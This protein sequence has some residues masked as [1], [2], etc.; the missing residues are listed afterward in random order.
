M[1]P[2]IF[3]CAGPSLSDAERSFFEEEQPAG[4]IL[5]ARNIVSPQQL[6]TLTTD[7]RLSVGRADVPILIDQ[8]GGRVQRMGPPHWQKYPA[9]GWYAAK[10]EAQPLLSRRALVLGCK[11]IADDLLRVGINV[12]CLPLLDVPVDGA[13]NI[14]G[15]RSFGFDHQTVA[16]LGQLVVTTLKNAGVHPVIKHIPGHGRAAVDSHL[17]L[18]LVSECIDVLRNTDFRPFAAVRGADFAMTAHI[19]YEAIDPDRPATLS[20]SVVQD[21]IR[22]EIGFD[23]LL[24]TDD[25]SMKALSGSFEDRAKQSLEAGCDLVLHCNGDMSEMRAVASATPVM[26]MVSQGK[27]ADAMKSIART[28]A[29]NR[30]EMTNEYNEL[31]KELGA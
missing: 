5:F 7:L 31:M 11:L 19:I 29:P 10:A 16:E 25:L 1:K 15:D 28:T 8:E 27:L 12:D 17:S 14:I 6:K 18:P 23:G 9:M 3:G 20:H 22:R 26:S 30:D 4:F 13:D 24:M 2:V 21:V